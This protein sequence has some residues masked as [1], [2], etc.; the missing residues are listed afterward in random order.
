MIYIHDDSFDQHAAY[1]QSELDVLLPIV[2]SLKESFGKTETGKKAL[3]SLGEALLFSY[4]QFFLNLQPKNSE[5]YEYVPSR[6]ICDFAFVAGIA[7]S[8]L[9]SFANLGAGSPLTNYFGAFT[10]RH[11]LASREDQLLKGPFLEFCSRHVSDGTATK[12]ATLDD[13]L[14]I[15][16][17]DPRITRISR[18]TLKS[19]ANE[20]G[21]VF[22][23]GRPKK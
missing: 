22:K 23:A 6:A 8:H 7:C 16:G 20:V 5:L 2:S 19:W 13:L 15:N 12:I 1:E 3:N 17:Y 4:G 14:N 10:A 11:A 9:S 18:R 21:I